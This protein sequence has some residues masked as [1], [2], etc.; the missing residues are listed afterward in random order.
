MTNEKLLRE[1]KNIKLDDCVEILH[2]YIY[3]IIKRV[4][5][6]VYNGNGTYYYD[7]ENYEFLIIAPNKMKKA[8]ILRYGYRDLHWVVVK[9]WRNQHVLSNALRTGIIKK[10]WVENKEITCCYDWN[11][12]KDEKLSITKHLAMLAGLKVKQ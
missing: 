1:L 5:Y 7:S 8:I 10:I 11:D 4:K 12:N 2:N 6:R 3:H 9:K